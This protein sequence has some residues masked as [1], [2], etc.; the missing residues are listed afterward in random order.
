M[1]RRALVLGLVASA[2]WA[3]RPLGRRLS[4]RIAGRDRFGHPVEVRRK[5]RVPA[6]AGR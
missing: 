6:A 2:A 1:S 4:V 3:R 5:L